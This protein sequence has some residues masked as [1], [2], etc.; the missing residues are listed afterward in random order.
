M[1]LAVFSTLRDALAPRVSERCALEHAT[2]VSPK[3]ALKAKSL[4]CGFATADGGAPGPLQKVEAA[5]A[6]TAGFEGAPDATGRYKALS[7]IDSIKQMDESSSSQPMGG[8]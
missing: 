2:R 8:Y 4:E 5:D 6:A 3:L 1:S 7:N